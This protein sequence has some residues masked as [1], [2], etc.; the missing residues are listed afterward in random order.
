MSTEEI[1]IKQLPAVTE[2]NNN[3]LILVQTPTSTNTLKF[4]DF[5]IGL[6]NTT[7][8][9][10][11]CANSSNI[12]FLSGTLDSVFFEPQYLPDGPNLL[13]NNVT[14][15][16]LSTF[17]TYALPIEITTGGVKRVY[18]FLLSGYN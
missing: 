8:A 7:F 14:S 18:K 15:T 17:D 5:V 11:I 9:P 12:D 3:D 6:E 13:T 4:Q 1:S 10:A 2:I 16:T